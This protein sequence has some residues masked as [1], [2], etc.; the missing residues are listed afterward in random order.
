MELV[1]VDEIGIVNEPRE[2]VPPPFFA[3]KKTTCVIVLPA[4]G[5][6][7][8]VIFIVEPLEKVAPFV[9]EVILSIVIASAGGTLPTVTATAADIVVAPL[10]SIAFAVKE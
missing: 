7:S 1:G 8:A 4:L 6:T 9:G 10:L 2:I 5:N 3:A